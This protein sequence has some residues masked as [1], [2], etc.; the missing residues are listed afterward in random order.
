M[1]HHEKAKEE[2]SDKFMHK[3]H[4]IN[5]SVRFGYLHPKYLV[6]VEMQGLC[7]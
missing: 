4:E 6:W 3:S 7:I 5:N 2:E 1:M